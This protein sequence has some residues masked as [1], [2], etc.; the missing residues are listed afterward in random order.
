MTIFECSRAR[1]CALNPHLACS[2]EVDRHQPLQFH[3]SSDCRLRAQS[4]ALAPLKPRCLQRISHVSWSAAMIYAC[5]LS[6]P[7]PVSSANTP[8][9]SP[10]VRWIALSKA[11]TL[12]SLTRRAASAASVATKCA[13]QRPLTCAAL[14]FLNFDLLPVCGPARLVPAGSKQGGLE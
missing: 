13:P 14:P 1:S 2:A 8:T 9:A 12:W 5:L 11:R 3:P 10:C 4:A 7:N 6:L